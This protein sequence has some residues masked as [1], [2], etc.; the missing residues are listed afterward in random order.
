MLTSDCRHIM[1][2]QGEDTA[3]VDEAEAGERQALVTHYYPGHRRCPAAASGI[4]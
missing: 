2:E 3:E 4:R 1:A